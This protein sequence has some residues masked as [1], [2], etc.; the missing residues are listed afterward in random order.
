MSAY[1]PGITADRGSASEGPRQAPPLTTSHCQR[2]QCCSNACVADGRPGKF[3]SVL[4]SSGTQ[5]DRSGV[6]ARCT[7]LLELRQGTDEGLD[8]GFQL[9]AR[10]RAADVKNSDVALY[11]EK[12]AQDTDQGPAYQGAG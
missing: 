3:S 12:Q 10:E 1:V 8:V 11:G 9:R 7:N 4:A 6:P 5:H 2:R